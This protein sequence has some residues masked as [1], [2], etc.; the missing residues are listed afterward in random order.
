MHCGR[1]HRNVSLHCG[2]NYSQMKSFLN[3]SHNCDGPS[4]CE[5]AN[6]FI[7]F[8]HHILDGENKKAFLFSTLYAGLKIKK[9]FIFTPVFCGREN[10]KTF[11]FHSRLLGRENKFELIFP[12]RYRKGRKIYFKP[13]SFSYWYGVLSLYQ[14]GK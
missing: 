4:K 1:T 5:G 2:W 3:Y 11:H 14:I 6:N 12:D 13:G 8:H 9:T 10:K 7:F